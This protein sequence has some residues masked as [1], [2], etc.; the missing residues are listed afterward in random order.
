MKTVSRVQLV[1]TL[2]PAAAILL[3]A[4]VGTMVFPVDPPF[5][6]R[7]V[8]ATMS[9][10]PLTGA[11]S[12]FGVF[13]FVAAAALCFL[14][15]AILWR[16]SRDAALFLLLAGILSG[17]LGFDD[18][19][20]FHEYLAAEHLGL[21]EEVV[22]G[23]LGIYTLAVGVAFRRVIARTNFVVL[24]VALALLA[25]SVIVDALQYQL[26]WIGEW[27]IF[28]EEGPKWLGIATWFSYFAYAAWHLVIR[29]FDPAAEPARNSNANSAASK[30]SGQQA[31]S[32]GS[33]AGGPA[34][35]AAS[36]SVTG[37]GR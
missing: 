1:I 32:G 18:Y 3:L 9:A 33:F 5:F 7:D 24:F 16:S 20:M 36:G 11:L 14:A 30:A 37:S 35:A 29:E 26:T 6:L 22:V 12:T 23:I 13:L 15:A 8:F 25:T 10:F 4:A 28:L 27:Y 31:Q 34:P 17:F 19:F 2:V 21:S